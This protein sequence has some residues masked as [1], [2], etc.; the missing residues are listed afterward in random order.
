MSKNSRPSGLS[1][2][3]MRFDVILRIITSH[4]DSLGVLSSSLDRFHE[5]WLI[6]PKV[7]FLLPFYA[8]TMASLTIPRWLHYSKKQQF[9]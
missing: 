6:H 7:Q 1:L 4:C 5:D 3:R 8:D 9:T 2:K